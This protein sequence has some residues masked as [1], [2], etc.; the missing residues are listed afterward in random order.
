MLK[1]K[2]NAAER[3]VA[4]Q[5][6]GSRQVD[7][8]A[9]EKTSQM[10]QQNRRFSKS[11]AAHTRNRACGNPPRRIENCR[12]SCYNRSATKTKGR[13]LHVSEWNQAA[14]GRYFITGRHDLPFAPA[15]GALHRHQAGFARPG[16]FQAETG[17]HP[18]TAF[19]HP[20]IPGIGACQL[21]G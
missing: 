17:G 2:R 21:C 11:D 15:A 9:R 4:E 10:I 13:N 5:F 7:G 18:Q 6:H 1:R 19:Q 16:V 20:E 8:A 12:A 14:A 3:K